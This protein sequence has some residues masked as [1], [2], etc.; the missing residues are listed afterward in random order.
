MLILEFKYFIKIFIIFLS[1]YAL[2]FLLK[3]K[4]ENKLCVI[5]LFIACA[6][7]LISSYLFACKLPVTFNTNIYVILNNLLWFLILYNTIFLKKLTSVITIGYLIFAIIN[8]VFVTGH[9]VFNDYTFVFGSFLYL[10]L[11]IVFLSHKFKKESIQEVKTNQFLL[12]AIPIPFFLGFSFLLGF[13]N[14][15]LLYYKLLDK[16]SLYHIISNFSNSIYYLLFAYYI[17]HERKLKNA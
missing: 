14:K 6:N 12:I 9:Q 10:I 7:E 17:Y 3:N 5:V 1:I 11:I 4:R 15:E 16:I 2:L 8:I 13:N